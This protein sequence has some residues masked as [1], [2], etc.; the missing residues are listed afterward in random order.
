MKTKTLLLII[1]AAILIIPF[2]NC[3]G[4]GNTTADVEKKIVK[5]MKKHFD[6]P[7]EKS[8]IA[9]EAV[10]VRN[11]IP[12]NVN[13]YNRKEWYILLKDKNII[14]FITEV[15]VKPGDFGNLA[16]EFGEI[17]IKYQDMWLVDYAVTSKE[18]NKIMDDY[19]K[20]RKDEEARKEAV[21]AKKN[22]NKKQY[23]DED[24]DTPAAGYDE[25]M[26]TSAELREIEEALDLVIEQFD[27][28]NEY[29]DADKDFI[30]GE[31]ST[32]EAQKNTLEL[33]AMGSNARQ[34]KRINRI[35]GKIN[36][37]VAKYKKQL[38]SK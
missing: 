15:G 33:A 7:A 23:V 3:G 36:K 6:V 10:L 1:A 21:E 8:Q 37:A 26:F 35:I 2:I 13:T 17:F 12:K 14:D 38:K 30:K 20:E 18:Y 19:D 27:T 5:F 11:A 4:G 16:P 31:I 34:E 32:L 25:V 9:L 29:A 22:K 28:A 24:D